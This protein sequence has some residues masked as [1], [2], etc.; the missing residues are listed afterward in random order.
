M[1]LDG[2]GAATMDWPSAGGDAKKEDPMQSNQ[3]CNE[4]AQ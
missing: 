3:L 1:K 4:A 2:A